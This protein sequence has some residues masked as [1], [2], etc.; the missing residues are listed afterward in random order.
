VVGAAFLAV[1]VHVE[2]VPR[3]QRAVAAELGGR[4][5]RNGLAKEAARPPAVGVHLL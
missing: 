1:G 4:A 5:A 3:R 2:K